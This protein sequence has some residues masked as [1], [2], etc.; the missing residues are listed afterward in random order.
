MPETFFVEI[1]SNCMCDGLARHNTVSRYPE[2]MH[3]FRFLSATRHKINP[4]MF[5]GLIF[6]IECTIYIP[7]KGAFIDVIIINRINVKT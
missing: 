1:V 5:Y 3:K 7:H 2:T 6:S 4:K